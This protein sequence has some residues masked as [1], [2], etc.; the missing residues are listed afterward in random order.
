MRSELSFG[1]E[2]TCT[3][4]QGLIIVLEEAYHKCFQKQLFQNLTRC[5]GKVPRWKTKSEKVQA[6]GLL[7]HSSTNTVA[8]H[9]FVPSLH[10]KT[11]F[12]TK[13]SK[14]ICSNS[15]PTSNQRGEI[16]AY[17]QCIIQALC[18]VNQ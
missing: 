12:P 15:G 5:P 13:K 7:L 10:L 16:S 18:V 1:W 17:Y 3:R 4:P 6:V 2:G 14:Q 8:K 11:P 9:I